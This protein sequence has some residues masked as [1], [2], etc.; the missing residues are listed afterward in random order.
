MRRTSYHLAIIISVLLISGATGAEKEPRPLIVIV[1][2]AGDLKGCSTAVAQAVWLNDLPVEVKPFPW[3]H[4]HYKIYKDQVD[5]RHS[6]AKGME[7][8]ECLIEWRR[9]RG[10]HRRHHQMRRAGADFRSAPVFADG[11]FV[12]RR[13][14]AQRRR[15]DEGAM[16]R[17]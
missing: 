8:A 12:G 2:G 14:V 10:A 3:S 6:R 15:G 1:D 17:L 16:R 4:G 7:L 13:P 9:E 5:D 11:F